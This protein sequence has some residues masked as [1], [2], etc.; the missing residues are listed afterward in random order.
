MKTECLIRPLLS[1]M[2]VAV[3][4]L[5]LCG[6]H[7][8]GETTS[9]AIVQNGRFTVTGD[10]IIEDTVFACVARKGGRI[11]SNLTLARLQAA[12]GDSALGVRFVQGKAWHRRDKRP[13]TLPQYSSE[14]RLVDALYDLS[15]DHIIDG[16]KSDG[17]LTVSS[18]NSRM[19]C[20]IFLSLA[21]LK[22]HQAMQT[23]KAMVDRDSIIM[24]IEGQWPVVSDH[25]GWTT[26]AWEVY[27]ATGDREWLAYCYRVTE[28]TLS[29][30]RQVL[31]DYNTD[32]VHGAGFTASRPMGARRMAWM[33]YN[34]LFSCMSLG[35]NILTG[36][37]Y[38]LLGD[39]GEELGIENEYQ[40]QAKRIKDAINQHLWN[41]NRG[42][43]SSFLYAGA[44]PRQAPLT[45][46]TSQAMCVLWGIADDD[47]AENLISQTPVSD[48]GVNVSYPPSTDIE[49]YFTNASWATTQAMWNLAAADTRNQNALK[50][51][52]GALYRAQALY[53]SRN[54]HIQ[55]INTDHLGTAAANAAM[56]L[57]VFM[58][59]SYKPEGIEFTPLVPNGLPGTKKLTGLNYRR[60]VLDITVQGVGSDIVTITDNGK[61]LES[62]FLPNDIEGHHHIA[63]TLKPGG[64]NSGKVTIHHGEVIMPPT[65]TVL[66][67]GDSGRITDYVP[68]T[69]YRLAVNGKLTPIND[70]V[71]AL[72]H[73]DGL[74]EYSVEIAG[75][76]INSYISQPYLVF[77]LTPQ[78]AFFPDSAG[79]HTTIKVSVAEGGDY[80]LDMG[81]H[82]TGT[83]DVREVIANTHPMGTLVMTR[84]DNVGIDGLAYSNMVSVKLL[85]GENIIGIRQ[86]RLPKTFTPCQPIHIRIIK[87]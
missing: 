46:N 21:W 57:R 45:D 78:I 9:R 8:G 33:T 47:R 51:G 41:E 37:A 62:A 32:L 14:Q 4:M 49:P 17:T 34:D 75:K 52:L 81:Y 63:I 86:I 76:Y 42:F 84:E 29:I 43:Y 3:G 58:G 40:N 28:K 7:K 35:N 60:A 36:N 85:K 74:A 38:A 73:V 79:G 53:Q 56:I 13:A 20:A 22:P 25:I 39:M 10:S 1:L 67:Q 18:S 80:L 72:P 59:M 82:P 5:C 61:P 69:S 6:C 83:L 31:Q 12:Y 54:I 16:I 65:P 68:G 87:R 66:W 30:N 55:G 24:Q 77:H 44:V 11:A 15:V 2:V 19:Y 70:S 48:C 27:K 23:L 50:R 26:A 64:H 71:F